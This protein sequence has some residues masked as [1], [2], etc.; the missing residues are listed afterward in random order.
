MTTD[1]FH[2][3]PTL[4]DL[5][6]E[7]KPLIR[8]EIPGE[9]GGYKIE[10]LLNV[11]GMSILYLGLDQETREPVTVKVLSKEYLDYPDL[12]QRF[13]KEAKVI[14]LLNHPNIVKLY[15]HGK[16]EEGLYI[17][18]EFV[19]GL[20]LRELILQQGLSLRKSLEIVQ[21]I[22][23]AVSH[24]HVH[25]I[26]HRDLK[27]ENILMTANG[28]I[29]VIDFGIAALYAGDEKAGGKKR[30]MGTPSY[31]APE[32][33]MDPAH[34]S[35]ASDIYSI[36]II[37]YEL[38]LG[39]L[40]HGVIHLSQ[41][42]KGIQ[43]ILSKALAQEPKERYGDVLEFLHDITTYLNSDEM[44]KELRAS[45]FLSELSESLKVAQNQLITTELPKWPRIELALASNTN[46]ALSSVYYDFFSIK[47]GVYTIVLGE[48]IETGIEGLIH[49]AQLRAMVRTLTRIKEHPK[50][51][52]ATLNDLIINE[53]KDQTFT[54]SY[55]TLFPM[56]NRFS[57]ISCGY[58]PLWYIQT[59]ADTPRRLMAENLAL[60]I[61][62]GMDILEVDSNWNI[63]DC[64]ILHT[65]QAQKTAGVVE[66]TNDL[67]LQAL[68][69]NL[70]VAPK[71]QVEAIFRKITKPQISS[72]YERPVTI[73]SAAR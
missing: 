56:E 51:L 24:L 44:K 3:E 40:C 12:V 46:A 65:F 49:M 27:P 41:V 68:K 28:T 52:I 47:N 17:A 13:M 60:G 53:A 18:M 54:L 9:I 70:F 32:L 15:K 34:V 38:V 45:D 43:K 23:K 14:E 26:I 10:S 16:W 1:A 11:G 7:A 72:L 22:C 6:V 25:E 66:E 61:D 21:E 57:Y 31:M 5:G 2:K 69:E 67:F 39:R 8:E 50:E 48:S 64:L 71:L 30:I 37:T 4:V 36:G 62:S 55:L 20:S 33:K 73:I 19:Q 58:S 63:G 42:P 59:G 35:F 29:K